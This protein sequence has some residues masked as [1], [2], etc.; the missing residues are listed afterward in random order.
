MLHEPL[1]GRRVRLEPL[2]PRHE[3]PLWEAAQDERVF[4]WFTV[5]ANESREAFHAWFEYA[6]RDWLAF[7]TVVDGR[8]LGS[9]SYG[10][11]RERDRVVEIGGTW[12]A[13][14]AWGTGANVEA[15]YLMLRHAFED[16]GFLR[17]EFKTEATNERSRAAL[18][19]LPAEFEGI[20]RRHML[21]RGGERRDSAW[22][23]VIDEDWPEVKAR[24]ERRLAAKLG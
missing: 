17:V 2:E 23:A 9:T 20:F 4:R 7:A 21:V 13:P 22:Y 15:K 3:E 14:E 1:T 8:P 19:A 16:E 24:L 18:A 6:R 5:R 10:N 12:L 11:V